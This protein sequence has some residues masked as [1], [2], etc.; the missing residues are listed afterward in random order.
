MFWLERLLP[1]LLTLFAYA[2]YFKFSGLWVDKLEWWIDPEHARNITLWVGRIVLVLVHVAAM[3][4]GIVCSTG[5]VFVILFLGTQLATVLVAVPVGC[6]A[7][8]IQSVMD[9]L[10]R[11]DDEYEEWA[12][13][14]QATAQSVL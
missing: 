2:A 13:L 10:S 14:S 5:L 1:L 12:T 11:A 6:A 3:L 8:A 7:F 9:R 4:I